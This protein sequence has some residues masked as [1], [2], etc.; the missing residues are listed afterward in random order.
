MI[1][2]AST[3][4]VKKEALAA[5]LGPSI[6]IE[7]IATNTFFVQPLGFKQAFQCCLDRLDQAKAVGPAV[8]I[9]IENYAEWIDGQSDL[10]DKCLVMVSDPLRGQLFQI[11][12]RAIQVPR[13]FWPST[14]STVLKE[15]IGSRIHAA[16]PEFPA[17]DWFA[18]SGKTT[19]K[20]QIGKALSALLHR[21]NT[22][23]LQDMKSYP[24][25]PKQGVNFADLFSLTANVESNGRLLDGLTARIEFAKHQYPRLA[26]VGLESRGLMLGYALAYRCQL[27]FIPARKPGKLPG[28]VERISFSK[29]YG[30]DELE[31]QREYTAGLTH[32]V[33]VDDV[34]ATGGS[35]EAAAILCRRIGLESALILALT[36]IA[37]LRSQ[38]QQRLAGLPV[39]L[40]DA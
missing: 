22:T 16:R 35:L 28:R 4:A 21:L 11:G 6:E 29:E 2:L 15:T 23:A 12:T 19:R 24:D 20:I 36:D 32:A 34:V 25:F 18:I 27:P 1:R 9:A 37:P 38:W 7:C 31:I 26:V 8:C 3:S 17:D 39:A 13:E 30:S 40:L 10:L 14:E 5:V 33:I